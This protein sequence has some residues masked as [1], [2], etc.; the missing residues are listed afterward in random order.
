MALNFNVDPYYD[1]F[2]A[3]KN[4]HR[5]LFKPGVAVQARELT[6]SQ[7]ILQDQITKFA[8]NIFKQNSPV[9]GGQVTTNFSCYYIKLKSTYNEIS[10]DVTDFDGLL[11]QN[12]TGSVRARVLATSPSTGDGGDPPTLVVSYLTQGRFVDNDIIYDTNSNLAAQAVETESTGLSSTAS[13]SR[14]VFYTLGNFVQVNESTVILSKY[15][16]TPTLRVGLTITE[17]N[18]DYIDDPSLLDPAIGESNYQAPGADRY[19]ISLKLD[20][21]PIQFGDDADFIEL[22]RIE[23]GSVY[24]MVDGSVYATIDDYFAKRDY[25]TNGDYVVNDFKL[26]P[27]TDTANSQNYIMSVGKGL[28]YVHGYRVENPAPIDITSPRARTQES[29]NNNPVYINYGNYLYVNN[30]RG[31]T[32]FYD[33]TTSESVDIHCVPYEHI[34]TSTQTAYNSTVIGVARIRNFEFDTSLGSYSNTA[35]YIYKAYIHDVQTYSLSAN[36][37]SATSNSVVLATN[38][39]SANGAYVGVNITISKGTNA[40]DYRYITSYDAVTRTATLNQNW[41]VVPDS[42]SVYIL[43]FDIKDAESVV[44]AT[45]TST[46]YLLQSRSNIATSGKTGNVAS[47]DTILENPLVPELIFNVGNQ[48]VSSITDTSYTTTQEFRNIAFTSTGV[49][50]ISAQL[51]YEGEYLNII[52]HL[53]TPGTTLSNDLVRQNYTIVCVNKGSNS[54]INVGDVIPWTTPNRSVTLDDDASIATFTSNDLSPFTA[55]VIA[56]VFVENGND[57]SHILKIKNYIKANGATI[58]TNG[59]QVNVNTYVD[60]TPLT[61]S[62]QVYI[63][64]AGL[65][66]PGRK[67][68]LYLSDV[69][70]V[71]RIIDTLS[72]DNLPTVEMVNSPLYDITNNYIFNNGQTDTFYDHAYLTLRPGASQPKGNILVFVNYYQHSGGDGY[73]SKLSYIDNATLNDDYKNLPVYRSTSGKA[74]NLRDCIDFRPSRTNATTDFVL[75]TSNPGDTTKKGTYIPSDTT[76]FTC[77]YAYYLGRK[78]KLILTKD[79]SIQI[80]EGSPSLTPVPPAEPDASLVIAI[81]T[82]NPYTGYLPSETSPRGL[83]DLSVDKVQHKRYTMRD[84]A[85][86]EYRISNVEYYTSLSL[87]EKNAESLQISDSYGLNRFKNGILVDDFSGYS[88]SDTYSEDFFSSINRR[89][90][91]MTCAQLVNNYPLR[92]YNLLQNLGNLS[93]SIAAALN[94]TINR[95]NEVNYYTL[96]YTSANLTSQKIASR[97]VNINPFSFSLSEGVA[98]LSP[99]IDNW[100][101]NTAAPSLL[102][103][104]PNL[105]V[106]RQSNT[107]NVLQVGDWQTISSVTVQTGSTTSS[108]GGQTV[109]ENHRGED[110]GFG[111]N[112]GRVTNWGGSSTTSFFQTTTQQLQNNIMGFYNNIGNTYSLNNGYLTD[113]SILPWMRAQQIAVRVNNLLQNAT[114]HTFFDGTNV[115]GYV[116]KANIIELTNVSGTFVDN[117]VVGYMSASNFVPT[118]RIL[119]VKNYAN[120]NSVRLYVAGDPFTTQYSNTAT[121]VSAVFNTSGSY[122]SSPASGTI[123][124]TS[125]YGGRVQRANSSTQ[126]QLSNLAP[127]ISGYYNG[128]T[129]SFMT[130][131]SAGR[132]AIVSGYDGATKTITL[133]SALTFAN[134]D[135]YSIGDFHSDTDG[136]FYCIFN[137]PA[138]VFHSGERVFRVD[139]RIGTNASSSTTHA[140][141]SFYAQG[142]ASTSQ[143]LDFGASPSGAKNTFT[144]TNNRTLVSNF[145]QTSESS[146]AASNPWDPVAQTFIIDAVNYPNGVFL[147]SLKIFFATKPSIDNSPITLSIVG[148]LNGYPNGETLDHSIVT[149][150]KDKVKTSSSP[151]YLDPNSYTEF[152]FNSPVYIQPNTLYAFILKSASNEYTLWSAFNGDSALASSVRNLPT[153]PLPSSITK[154]N[155]APY[156][157]SLFKSQNA[158]TW[159]T[160]QN[161]SLMFTIERCVFDI[162]KTPS[163]RFV[164]PKMLPQRALIEQSI[165]YVL[166]ANNVVANNSSTSNTT[167]YVDAFN[168]TTTDFLPTSTTIQYSYSST[169]PNGTSPGT[170]SINPGK[171]AASMPENI[172][173]DDGNG[174]RILDANTDS[175]FSVYAQLL[176]VSNTVSPVLSDAGLTVYAIEHKINN[177]ELSNTLITVANTGSGYNANTTLVTVSAPTG[178]NGVQAYAVANVAN[179][180]IQSVYI[181]YPGSGYIE[182]PSIT[183]L[184]ANTTPGTG[185]NVIISGE[186]STS[187]G[188]ALSK[189]VTKRVTLDAGYDSGDLNV[190]MTA[191]RPVGTDIQVYYKILNRN[192][193][194]NFSDVN[195][196]LMTKIRN[197]DGLYAQARGDFYEYVFAP[198]ING[199]A[200]GYVSY[201]TTSGLSYTSFSQF[202][203]KVVLTTSDKTNIPIVQDIRCI[204]LPQNATTIF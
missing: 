128:N 18:V 131:S 180:T 25:E 175:S 79:R 137:L 132:S 82:H 38:S 112:V 11:V 87:L 21:R 197:S 166:N 203:I 115:D 164:V 192:D 119:G 40:G 204:A 118:A 170:I 153:D 181:T 151:H 165:E 48:Y 23:E 89:T 105:Q 201:T 28:A 73:F 163:I 74:Y 160:D 57:T 162:T 200:N 56:K 98:S 34:S 142:L 12:S 35:S 24:K 138:N 189:Y 51:N 2:D 66:D 64:Q 22:V 134:N 124:S 92:N 67:Q 111:M 43:D 139:N 75:R 159:T 114:L 55:T 155:S 97:S 4:F 133:N 150:P 62:G 78:D 39:S 156:V 120:T 37:V 10:F 5:I 129:I 172:H 44:T 123:S 176:S 169:L 188:P 101:D 104:D 85:G 69:K 52:R 152:T 109:E 141:A 36:V 116:R 140:Q 42:T 149:V 171:L 183:I 179:G 15:D 60:D 143:A 84:I 190:Y 7:S 88:T 49:G 32:S 135:I 53:G 130:G 196:N 33:V 14:G 54:T 147:K 50:S 202:A 93:P 96:P 71:V 65:V 46:P 127:A 8:D 17:S 68:S 158:Q 102:I 1:D 185:A 16:N 58:V 13:I 72:V 91:Q 198:G 29:Q 80:I 76:V 20:S 199:S 182:T 61:S 125:H 113:I 187:G 148:T 77:D 107:V 136:N 145:S 108:W 103:V 3:S 154:I 117:D 95:D 99:N 193:T 177:C 19:L 186:T 83:P 167:M 110:W 174:R 168:V 70:E 6:Q 81:L 100:V 161:E 184:D 26:T 27:K 191:Y 126:L 122:Q 86:L 90:R 106:F 9:T 31:N 94:Y 47:G 45:K 157:G 173:L 121:L 30:V 194:T 195:W 41:T 144:Q 59:T 63:K 146:W 178:K